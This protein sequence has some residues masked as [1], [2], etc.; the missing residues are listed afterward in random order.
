MQSL[1]EYLIFEL[2]SNKLSDAAKSAYAK[3]RRSQGNRFAV[4]AGKALA[5]ELKSAKNPVDVVATVVSYTN[6]L[7]KAGLVT[8][9]KPSGNQL[10]L[11]IPLITCD[12][13]GYHLS[14]NEIWKTL[15]LPNKKYFIY[16]DFY[17][18]NKPHLSTFGD[19][20]FMLMWAEDDFEDFNPSKDIL[21]SSDDDQDIAKWYLKYFDIDYD[22]AK[23]STEDEFEKMWRNKTND[24]AW[25]IHKLIKGEEHIDGSLYY[26]P[27]EIA[28]E[29]LCY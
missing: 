13:D 17:R 28:N 19:M 6:E 4:A 3:G 21:Y 12:S 29:L 2:S 25:F 14:E 8:D 20:L 7:K 18:G 27:K 11:E 5:K 16:K 26:D 15:K 1:N 10:N 22:D 23:K 9:K 24:A